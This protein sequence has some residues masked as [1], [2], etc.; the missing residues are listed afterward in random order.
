MNNVRSGAFALLLGALCGPSWAQWEL[1]IKHPLNEAPLPAPV[2][3]VEDGFKFAAAGDLLG[4]YRLRALAG[5]P[6]IAA[7]AKLFQN[8]DAGFA[9]LEANLFDVWEFK[10]YPAAE[11]GG[12]EQGGVGSGPVL[13][14][15]IATE[16]RS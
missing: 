16:L 1:E 15:A 8:A 5:D 11:N 13:P 14:K 6:E 4:P 3:S 12:F 9:N 10:G 2:T 7:I